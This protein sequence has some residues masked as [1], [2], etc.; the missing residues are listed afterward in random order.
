MKNYFAELTKEEIKTISD[1]LESHQHTPW[2]EIGKTLG[3]DTE[4]IREVSERRI[5]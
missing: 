2:S 3:F 5:Q 1:Y 4:T